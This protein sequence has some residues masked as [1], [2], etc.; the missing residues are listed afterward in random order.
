MRK[1][2]L[3]LNYILV[4]LLGLML[5]IMTGPEFTEVQG[6]VMLLVILTPIVVVNLVYAHSMR[7]KKD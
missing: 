2:T 6:G 1:V 5:I 4:G 7:P 3:V